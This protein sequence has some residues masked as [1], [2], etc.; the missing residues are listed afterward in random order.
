[1]IWGT[2]WTVVLNEI[3]RR[4]NKVILKGGVVGVS[5]VFTLIQLKSWLWVVSKVPSAVFSYSEWCLDPLACMY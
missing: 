3:S 2:I 4:K 5:K 1:M